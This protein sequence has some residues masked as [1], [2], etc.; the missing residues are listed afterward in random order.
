VFTPMH[1]DAEL[2]H[3]VRFGAWRSGRGRRRSGR[4]R[5]SG[6]WGGRGILSNHSDCQLAPR[7]SP[8]HPMSTFS[9]LSGLTSASRSPSAETCVS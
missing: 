7:R 4:G 3:S 6:R 9:G 1:V 8:D 2:D 5:G